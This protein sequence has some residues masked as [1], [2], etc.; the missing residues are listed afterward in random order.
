MDGEIG[1]DPRPQLL[2]SDDACGKNGKE[3]RASRN[4]TDV[5]ADAV[6]DFAKAN[7]PGGVHPGQ[8]N[9]TALVAP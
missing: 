7:S 9:G 3:A 1:A 6:Q 8:P 5:A 4:L 2:V